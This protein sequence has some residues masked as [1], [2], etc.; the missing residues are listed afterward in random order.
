[1]IN[2]KPDH[3]EAYE[4]LRHAL[5]EL[6]TF[7]QRRTSDCNS[8]RGGDWIKNMCINN[9][10]YIITLAAST[11]EA[12][13]NIELMDMFSASPAQNI[14]SLIALFSKVLS[15]DARDASEH[16]SSDRSASKPHHATTSEFGKGSQN[17]GSEAPKRRGRPL[18]IPLE[19][20]RKAAE[21]VG[22]NRDR[23]KILYQTDYPNGQ[24]VKNVPTVLRKYRRRPPDAE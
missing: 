22:T 16:A 13:T 6:E 23:A 5:E 8:E 17:V 10:P 15:T 4:A 3:A 18:R 2:L 9:R 20:K 7:H 24:Q 11:Q 1:M 21:I 12:K 14:E 19:L